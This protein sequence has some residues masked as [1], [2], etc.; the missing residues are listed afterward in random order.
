M[1]RTLCL[2]L[3]RQRDGPKSYGT[4]L[5]KLKKDLEMIRIIKNTKEL[6]VKEVENE[7]VPIAEITEMVSRKRHS[8]DRIKIQ[9]RNHCKQLLS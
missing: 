1:T 4:G 7:R 9:I 6:S 8:R 2:E 3:Q 5:G